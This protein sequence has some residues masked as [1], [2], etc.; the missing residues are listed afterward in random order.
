MKKLLIFVFALLLSA[1]SV[2]AAFDKTQSYDN[3]FSD[4]NEINWY[5]DNVKTAYE[6]GFMNGKSVN[7]FDPDGNVTVAEAL[8]TLGVVLRCTAPAR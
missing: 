6:L 3:N 8:V 5:Y 2:N 1:I 7:S 4:V